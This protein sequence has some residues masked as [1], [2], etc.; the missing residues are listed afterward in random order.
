MYCDERFVEIFTI[1][2]FGLTK[3]KHLFELL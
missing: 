2:Y 3:N 1:F